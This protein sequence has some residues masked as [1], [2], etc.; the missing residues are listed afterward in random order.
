M[1]QVK[2]SEIEIVKENPFQN[3]RLG[4]LSYAEVLKT[5]IT[6][7]HTGCVISINGEWGAGKTTFIKMFKQML[8]N[9]GYSTLYFNAWDTD[10]ISD[11]IIGLLGEMK[12]I[13]G[14]KTQNLM[15]AI[16]SI[17]T[18]M[19]HVVPILGKKIVENY[20]GKEAAEVL[21]GVLEGGADIFKREIDRYKEEQQS[22]LNFKK[23]LGAFV[24]DLNENKP[25]V[26]IVDE[27]DRCTPHYAVKV[28]ERIKH[29]FSVQQIVFLVSVDK[30]QLCNSIRGYYG[31]DR[32]DAEEYLRRFFDLEYV[33][34]K[35][36]YE[37]FVK[38][39]FDRLDFE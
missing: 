16:D 24:K 13:R 30:G 9:D 36:D 35:P 5:L 22:I 17:S 4:R 26:F 25:L 37:E 32:I 12:T 19:A 23:F 14:G 18:V 1:Y 33:L 3:C 28:L 21:E 7:N 10:Y 31:S 11:P 34:P 8:E 29:L 15:T 6:V 20:I 27:L 38:F 39:E 2:P